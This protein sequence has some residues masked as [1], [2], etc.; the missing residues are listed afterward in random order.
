MYI[1]I[2]HYKQKWW[3][4]VSLRVSFNNSKGNRLTEKIGFAYDILIAYSSD[5][6]IGIDYEVIGCL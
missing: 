5:G 1:C 4:G 2:A 3:L 6:K